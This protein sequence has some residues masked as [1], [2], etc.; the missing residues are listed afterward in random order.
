MNDELINQLAVQVAQLRNELAE[1]RSLV[2][3]SGGDSMD[4]LF[5]RIGGTSPG[6]SG[7]HMGNTDDSEEIDGD[8]TFESADD[9]NVEVTTEKR[10]E[11]DE[12]KNV[13]KIG[14]YYV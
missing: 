3:E 10:T 2:E 12:E 7:S 14:V 4:D 8:V 5:L 9:S 1:L 13:I 11:D 6:G